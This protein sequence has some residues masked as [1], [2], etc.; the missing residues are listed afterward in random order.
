[1]YHFWQQSGSFSVTLMFTKMSVKTGSNGVPSESSK[2]LS[3]GTSAAN[4]SLQKTS[5]YAPYLPFG[6]KLL[7]TQT[8]FLKKLKYN[9]AEAI[10]MQGQVLQ[11]WIDAFN[12]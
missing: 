11:Q 4:A 5:K 8:N 1:M 7:E 3:N 6:E 10:L 12:Q 2:C 9:L